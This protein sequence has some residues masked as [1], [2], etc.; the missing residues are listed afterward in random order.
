MHVKDIYY[1]TQLN[2]W[3]KN[4]V[5]QKHWSRDS[6]LIYLHPTGKNSAQTDEEK[7]RERQRNEREQKNAELEALHIKVSY[8]IVLFSWPQHSKRINNEMMLWTTILEGAWS[9]WSTSIG[10]WNSSPGT[11]LSGRNEEAQ[12]GRIAKASHS[13]AYA[14]ESTAKGFVERSNIDGVVATH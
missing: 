3:M 2:G 5:D 6:I 10:S 14:T 7:Q 12:G 13:S 11:P 8:S 1:V 9:A 4:V